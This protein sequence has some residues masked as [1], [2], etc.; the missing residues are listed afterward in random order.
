MHLEKIRP[1]PWKAN[2][3]PVDIPTEAAAATSNKLE[4]ATNVLLYSRYPLPK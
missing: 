3:D 1:G 4:T 2:F